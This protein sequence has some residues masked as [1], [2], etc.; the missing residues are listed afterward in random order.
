MFTPA[1]STPHHRQKGTKRP[2]LR[3]PF[4]TLRRRCCIMLC[5]SALDA[6][7]LGE[8]IA[9]VRSGRRACCG[10]IKSVACSTGNGIDIVSIHRRNR[11]TGPERISRVECIC[12]AESSN[13]PPAMNV[14]PEDPSSRQGLSRPC[15]SSRDFVMSQC[16]RMIRCPL[17]R[18]PS[19]RPRMIMLR[20]RH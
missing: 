12:T 18:Q 1:T 8:F 20:P 13:W 6:M 11:R 15:S 17:H 7:S 16:S 4:S 3:G 19:H 5:R 2:M 10:A 9:L 14:P